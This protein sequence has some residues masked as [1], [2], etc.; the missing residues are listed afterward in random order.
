MNRLK[1]NEYVMN[2]LLCYDTYY[3]L[4]NSIYSKTE[5]TLTY[6]KEVCNVYDHICYVHVLLYMLEGCLPPF[7]I[8]DTY[9]YNIK[10][11]HTGLYDNYA[12]YIYWNR[13]EASESSKWY[14]FRGLFASWSPGCSDID[15]ND[16]SIFCM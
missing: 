14:A 9:I 12:L 4:Y 6:I 15:D 8:N 3:L 2:C 11:M 10:K 5:N 7:Y 16:V 1:P 13:L